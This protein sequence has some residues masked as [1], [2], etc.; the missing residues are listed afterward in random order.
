LTERYGDVY[1]ND[2][3]PVLVKERGVAFLQDPTVKQQ[4]FF[5]MLAPPCA[6]D[7]FIAEP[8]VRACDPFTSP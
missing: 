3:L 8:Q 5:M 7:P 4:P 1:P 6:H 2:Y